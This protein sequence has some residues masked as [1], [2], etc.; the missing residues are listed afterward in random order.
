MR[1]ENVIERP[2]EKAVAQLA[3]G[4]LEAWNSHDLERITEF[5]DLRYEG[6]DVG[7]AAPQIGQKGI[8]ESMARYLRAFPDLRFAEEE[9]IVKHNRIVLFWTATGKHLGPLLNIPPTGKEV[10][11]RGV[12]M[13]TVVG[14]KIKRGIHIWDLAGFLRSIKLLPEL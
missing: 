8:K 7:E 12:T 13:L 10:A 11:V 14:G 3:S 6:T 1:M 5:Y 9:V 2:S 4:L